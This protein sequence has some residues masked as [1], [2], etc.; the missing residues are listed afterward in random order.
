MESL[1]GDVGGA[2]ERGQLTYDLRLKKVAAR[3]AT[4][5]ASHGGDG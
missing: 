2:K 1:V 4:R 3:G 5:G